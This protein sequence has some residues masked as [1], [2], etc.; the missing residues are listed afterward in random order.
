MS[1]YGTITVASRSVDLLPPTSWDL[2]QPAAPGKPAAPFRR[3][4]LH[5]LRL[6]S[7]RAL[8][9]PGPGLL[10]YTHRIFAAE[11]EAG[12]TYPQEAVAGSG[13]IGE[14]PD[15]DGG[16]TDTNAATQTYTR[17]A[18]EAY[19]WAA[20]VIV[21]IGQ[22]DGGGGGVHVLVGDVE[23][24]RAG[25]RW[26]DA[27]V[28]FYYVKPNYPGRSSH[29][30]SV[31]RSLCHF[32]IRRHTMDWADCATMSDTGD[33]NVFADL[34]CRL[35]YSPC[36]PGIWI[37]KDPGQVILALRPLAWIQS[38]RL[39]PGLCKQY[40]EFEVRARHSVPG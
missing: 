19:F 6:D 23:A 38:K 25:R 13:L 24:S 29:V 21:A 17:A 26:E 10:D 14:Q 3:L 11:I 7:A 20:D 34:Q 39:Q 40:R 31:L 22:T 37:W 36:S 18:F 4:V 27:L 33:A 12:R 15:N 16:D 1:A 30:S 32:Y 9:G 8:P 5:H 35:Y 28:G 2:P